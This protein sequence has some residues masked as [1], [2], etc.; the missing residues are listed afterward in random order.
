[1]RSGANPLIYYKQVDSSLAVASS[2][3]RLLQR[4]AAENAAV[5]GRFSSSGKKIISLTSERSK[6]KMSE[7][8]GS[9]KARYTI[10]HTAKLGSGLA[11]GGGA[12]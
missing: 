12:L 6:P 4:I 1:M 11:A 9:G 5:L 8:V 3:R 2:R 7:G 10:G